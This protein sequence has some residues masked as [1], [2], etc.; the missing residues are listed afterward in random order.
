MLDLSH[1]IGTSKEQLRIK[2]TF[3]L[4]YSDSFE[5]WFDNR[6]MKYEG[7]ADHND[8]EVLEESVI[9]AIKE[10]LK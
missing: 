2:L 7:I 4:Q 10:K 3:I 9:E 6:F 8:I 5:K 1:L